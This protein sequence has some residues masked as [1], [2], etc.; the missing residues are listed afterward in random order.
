MSRK[1]I[2]ETCN[3]CPYMKQVKIEGEIISY[4]DNLDDKPLVDGYRDFSVPNF[5]DLDDI[6]D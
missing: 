1:I 3:D 4:C 5:C 2:V 6:Y